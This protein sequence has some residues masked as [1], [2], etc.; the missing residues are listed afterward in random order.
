MNSQAGFW[1]QL[2]WRFLNDSMD[3]F[4]DACTEKK[5]QIEC[6][7]KDLHDNILKGN[8]YYNCSKESNS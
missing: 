6:S 3:F 1:N 7:Q 5:Q 2:F 4:I 8:I